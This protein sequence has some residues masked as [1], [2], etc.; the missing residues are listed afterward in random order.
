MN[1]KVRLLARPRGTPTGIAWAIGETIGFIKGFT[2]ESFRI[3]LY[4]R[5]IGASDGVRAGTALMR[6]LQFVVQRATELKSHANFRQFRP[7]WLT[8]NPVL[9]IATKVCLTLE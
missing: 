4:L 9:V 3:V 8:L 6:P 2:N 7:H 1:R 5:G